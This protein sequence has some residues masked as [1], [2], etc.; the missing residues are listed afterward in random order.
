MLNQNAGDS[1]FSSTANNS[2]FIADFHLEYAAVGQSHRGKIIHHFLGK[3]DRGFSIVGTICRRS[4]HL[5]AMGARTA[6]VNM[7]AHKSLSALV[8]ATL[9]AIQ[10]IVATVVSALLARKNDVEAICFKPRLTCR[11]NLPGKVRLAFPIA[12][13]TRVNT[14]MAGVKRNGTYAHQSSTV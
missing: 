5:G 8:N 4:I 2:E 10:E 14:A 11:N 9:N 6:R 1:R 12:L 3:L 7:E 13:R